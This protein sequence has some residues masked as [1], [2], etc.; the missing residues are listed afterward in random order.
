M[1]NGENGA[2]NAILTRQKEAH[3]RDGMPSAVKRIEWLE[4]SIDL[5][6]S[7]ANEL[8]DAMSADFGHRSSDQSNLTDI[9]QS[10]ETLKHARKHVARWMRPSKRSEQ[11]PLNLLG[12]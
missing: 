11:F 12:A 5:I 10:I 6:H 7:H 9:S 8:N 2:M 3:L 1:G 4:K